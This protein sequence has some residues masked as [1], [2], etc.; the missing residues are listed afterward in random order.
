MMMINEYIS[1]KP[2]TS[3]LN[4][5]IKSSPSILA[6]RSIVNR[7]RIRSIKPKMAVGQDILTKPKTKWT[8]YLVY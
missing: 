2:L 8:R 7:M 6:N 4:L 1:Y 5:P 3:R